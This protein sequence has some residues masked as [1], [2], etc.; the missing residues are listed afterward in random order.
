MTTNRKFDY[1]EYFRL[2]RNYEAKYG[3]KTVIIAQ[4]GTF[5]DVFE[6]D[7]PERKEGK[8]YHI[9]DLIYRHKNKEPAVTKSRPGPHQIN[10]PYMLGLP[11]KSFEHYKITFLELG[12][13]L[14]M[15]EQKKRYV[16]TN[17][18]TKKLKITREV[19]KILTK[20]TDID[21]IH[22]LNSVSNKIVSLVFEVTKVEK[23]VEM[24][25][26]TIGYAAL[27]LISGKVETVELYGDRNDPQMCLLKLSRLLSL[28]PKELLIHLV[29][30][31]P[32]YYSY[33]YR[34][35]EL[36]K[37]PTDAIIV[38][39]QV[40]KEYFRASY[41]TQI[42]RK[43]YPKLTTSEVNHLSIYLTAGAS[44]VTLLNYCNDHNPQIIERISIPG[45]IKS[46]RLFI[47]RATIIHLNLYDSHYLEK[48]REYSNI[49]SLL[50][51]IDRTKTHMGKRYLLK[52]L[53]QP[54][55]DTIKI[56]DSLS[57]IADLVTERELLLD[58]ITKIL[59]IIPD[60]D[61]LHRKLKIGSIVPR[62][63]ARLTR[64]YLNVAKILD[65]LSNESVDIAALTKIIPNIGQR[66]SF[67]T[68]VDLLVAILDC[69]VCSDAKFCENFIESEAPIFKSLNSYQP[70]QSLTNSYEQILITWKEAYGQI[71]AFSDAIY[72]I[73]E[74]RPKLI[75]KNDRYYI[76]VAL[77]DS[78]KIKKALKDEGVKIEAYSG[79]RA[80]R[81]HIY[82]TKLAPH[83]TK[84]SAIR[85]EYQLMTYQIYVILLELIDK[86]YQPLFGVMSKFLSKLDYVCSGANVA[87][88]YN[89]VRPTIKVRNQD[90]E[91]KQQS[92]IKIKDLRH[93]IV[94]RIIDNEFIPNDL[95]LGDTKQARGMLLFGCNSSGKSTI[96]KA[97]GIAIILAQAGYYVPASSCELVPYEHLITRLS[98]NDNMF[99]GDSSFLIE[100]KELRT[101][102]K[103]TGVNT[104]VLGDEMCRG[105]GWIEGAA[106][107][108]DALENL[109]EDR[110]NF[111]FSTHMHILTDL[112]HL[113]KDIDSGA[114][115]V[116]HLDLLCDEDGELAY[117]RKLRPGRG[118]TKYGIE[119]ARSVGLPKK[120]IERAYQIR[121]D[122]LKYFYGH[123]D[124]L[125][126]PKRSRYNS[127]VYMHQCKLC[128][129]R[130]NLETHHI[131]AQRLANDINYIGHVP[132][133][134]GYNLGV[135]CEKCHNMTHYSVKKINSKYKRVRN[136]VYEHNS[137]NEN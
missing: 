83:L 26:L 134:A 68:Y 14:V 120:F 45:L 119:V 116:S 131:R 47:S 85:I 104:L 121:K 40:E 96:T 92:Y 42:L 136:M 82:T 31:P 20:G 110:C 87:L 118:R 52:R 105:T 50:S 15:Y 64:G 113:K 112:P 72:S 98:G 99:A 53:N 117:N 78:K 115:Q 22:C 51:I 7:L 81:Y 2:Q 58:P 74:K 94:E 10:N 41:Q 137:K 19:T 124:E 33:L 86:E 4:L 57:A 132:K 73:V 39:N 43:V 95:V 125:L 38:R 123:N 65:L 106:L 24:S 34:Y 127:G 84:A 102:L 101:I 135:L 54:Y 36:N 59:T 3:P 114:L 128:G 35:L 76:T 61:L 109:L 8:A 111:I 18:G 77:G 80:K 28:Q 62:D 16:E 29:S 129:S 60:M 6:Y 126:N 32:K 90:Q 88:K 9:Q 130:E 30:A 23:K 46:N 27:D 1:E 66:N 89:Y 91:E 5:Y 67:K 93:P 44:L 13:T 55:I 12:Y 108:V 70:F 107:T 25:A 79:G 100:M 75:Y 63:L 21:R 11:I 71:L 69:R 103:Y 17:K 48:R 37:Y 97:L 56:N 49:T 122:I 133:D